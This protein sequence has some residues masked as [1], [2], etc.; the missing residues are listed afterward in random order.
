MTVNLT[1]DQ[2]ILWQHGFV[3]LN[4]TIV[5]TWATM[6]VMSLGAK[7]ITRKLKTEGNISRWQGSLEIVVTAMEEQIK[8]VGLSQP[9]KYLS[10]LG[11]LFLFVATASLCTMI[12]GYKPPTG[13]TLDHGGAGAVCVCCRT[14]V[15]HQGAG[16]H[17]LP[18]DLHEADVHHAAVQ[19]HQ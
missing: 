18:Q 19:H 16:V 2:Q 15:W 17:C 4:G 3:K 14:S 13:F 7:L 11:T 9:A 8:E 5:T 6:I 12:P 1:S 10:F